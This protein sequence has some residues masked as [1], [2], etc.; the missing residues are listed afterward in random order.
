MHLQGCYE[1]I[2]TS[3]F[4][5]AP[6]TFVVFRVPFSISLHPRYLS[7][8]AKN[9]EHSERTPINPYLLP[10][11]MQVTFKM[12]EKWA[13]ERVAINVNDIINWAQGAD[14]GLWS[15]SPFPSE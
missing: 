1:P 3:H 7:P 2:Q 15:V 13:M 6:R 8:P 12:E 14:H 9:L 11:L 5:K 4:R 10:L